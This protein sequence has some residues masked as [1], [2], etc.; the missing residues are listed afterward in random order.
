MDI[1]INY[2]NSFFS[3]LRNHAVFTLCCILFMLV[4]PMIFEYKIL[5]ILYSVFAMII[6]FNVI[7]SCS[8]SIGNKHRRNVKI[9]NRKLEEQG[10]PTIKHNCYSGLIIAGIY[11]VFNIIICIVCF[12]LSHSD[13]NWISIVGNL[14]YKFWFAPFIFCFIYIVRL[15]YLLWFMVAITPSVPIILGYING[16][17]GIKPFEGFINKLVYKN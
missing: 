17:K 8:W 7:F 11:A 12:I 14:V 5:Q 16:I 4:L 1:K 10:E 9:F 3:L 15:Q 13:T 2:I 6:A